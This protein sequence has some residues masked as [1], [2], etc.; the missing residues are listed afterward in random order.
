MSFF[1]IN[2]IYKQRSSTNRALLIKEIVNIL[3]NEIISVFK[4]TIKEYWNWRATHLHRKYI[5]VT[6]T[7][8]YKFSV[9]AAKKIHNESFKDNDRSF[10][11]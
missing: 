9:G 5:V 8:L 3:Y 6:F 10:S 4:K 11:M 7:L 1:K 2:S